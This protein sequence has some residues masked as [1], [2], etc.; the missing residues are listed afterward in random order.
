MSNQ[1]H[2]GSIAPSST[3]TPATQRGVQSL[4]HEIIRAHRGS[5]VAGEFDL[6]VGVGIPGRSAALTASRLGLNVALI[7]NRP[8]LGGNGS[9]EIGLTLRGK[10][11]TIVDEVARANPD[12]LLAAQPK[13]KPF[14]NW[15]TFRVQK[16]GSRIA[17]VDAKHTATGQELR[18]T[19]PLFIDCTGMGTVGFLAGAE[20]RLGR[21]ARSQFNEGLAPEK[22]DTFH[23]GNSPV[24][25]YS[26]IHD[27]TGWKTAAA[28]SS[29][30]S[31]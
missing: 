28:N 7:Q 5:R 31:G 17:S 18:F 19:A 14:L 30:S 4:F 1:P 25:R 6:V 3:S 29:S 10:G 13:L 23:H 11:R 20:Y 27:I 12:K 26:K 22:A 2:A 9:P 8:V 15:H 24:F 16:S 21:E